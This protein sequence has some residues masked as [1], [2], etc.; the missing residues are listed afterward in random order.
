M[1]SMVADM[2]IYEKNTYQLQQI[3]FTMSIQEKQV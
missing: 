2:L 3:D 1:V